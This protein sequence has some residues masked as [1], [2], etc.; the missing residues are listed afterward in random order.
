MSYCRLSPESDVYVYPGVDEIVCFACRLAGE[1]PHFTTVKRSEMI[2]HLREHQDRGHKVPG[3]AFTRLEQE[4][5]E[6]GD[7]LKAPEWL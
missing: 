2:A 3:K 4:L 1:Q 5:Q 7:P 6:L